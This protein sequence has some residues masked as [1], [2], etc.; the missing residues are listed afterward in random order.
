MCQMKS[1]EYMKSECRVFLAVWH[2]PLVMP[3]GQANVSNS[4]VE[5]FMLMYAS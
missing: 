1:L 4:K 2:K 5:H 3:A